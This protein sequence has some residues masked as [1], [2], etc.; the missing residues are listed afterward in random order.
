MSRENVMLFYSVLDRDPALRAR[1]LGLRKTLKDQEEVLS[2][3]LALAAE[4]GLP[5]T[6]EEYLSVQYER[7]SFVD[8]EENIR[9]KR[10]S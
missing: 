3:F 4:A 5:F 2:A 7:A 8:T 10:K 1:A 6:L 9:R